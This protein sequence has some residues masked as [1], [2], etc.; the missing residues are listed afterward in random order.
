MFRH[1][2]FQVYAFGDPLNSNQRRLL[3]Y[4]LAA[5][6]TALMDWMH[7]YRQRYREADKHRAW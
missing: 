3:A 2:R 1:H 7:E 4:M 6:Q 5:L